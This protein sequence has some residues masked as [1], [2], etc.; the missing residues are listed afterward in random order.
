MSHKYCMNTIIAS[1][2]FNTPYLT[3]MN[4]PTQLLFADAVSDQIRRRSIRNTVS[5]SSSS[6]SSMLLHFPGPESG[7][8][9]AFFRHINRWPKCFINSVW[10][11]WKSVRPTACWPH[12]QPTFFYVLHFEGQSFPGEQRALNDNNIVEKYNR[13]YCLQLFQGSFYVLQNWISSVCTSE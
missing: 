6:P 8:L 13:V 10:A 5:S 3:G 11:G 1:E 2:Y 4:S 12:W 9:E 7:S